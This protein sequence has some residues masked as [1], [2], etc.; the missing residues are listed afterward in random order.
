MKPFSK[1]TYI[2]RRSEL[3]KRVGSGL[4]LFLGNGE[5]P[6]NYADNTYHF[7]QDSSFHYFFG[8]DYAGLA[9]VIDIDTDT[10]VIFGNEL[11]IDDIVWMGYQPSLHEKCELVG[12]SHT[13]PLSEL[14]T[15]VKTA[16]SKG[17]TIHFLP[18][19]RGEHQVWLQELL[20]IN[21]AEQAAKASLP[22]IRAIVDMRN[23]KTAEEI[24]HIEAAVDVSVDMHLAA[25]RAARPGVTEAQIAAEVE[26]ACLSQDCYKAFPT[27]A[28]VKGQTLHQHKFM[29]TL[30]AGQIF[31]LDAGAED[32]M[33]YAGDLSSSMPVSDRFTPEQEMIYNLHLKTFKAATDTLVPGVP[34]R[35]AHMNAAVCLCEGMKEIGLMK[36]DPVDAAYS[37]AYAMFFP[38]GL[39]HMMGLDV[40]DME[41]LGEQYVGYSDGEKKSTQFGFKSLRLA[42]KLEPGFVFTVEPGIYFI[43]ELIDKW[44]AEH[45]FTDFICYDKLEAWKG[46]SGL[47]NELDY[48]I[49]EDGARVLGHKQKPMTVEEVYA[50]KNAL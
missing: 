43:P 45:Q 47:R 5:A 4:L 32:P 26:R 15:C 6:M 20:G 36:G 37:G 41:N 33:H 38:C 29:N 11:T 22:M 49:T 44:R 10:E 30:E 34:F 46:F 7:R 19:Y 39:G 48:L 17:Q 3:K 31:L 1:E 35:Q 16:Q 21:P 23:H 24:E 28:T 13:M 27:I 9:A 40:H 18:P 12:I 42:R 50:A 2:Q 8:S 14:A 25:Y